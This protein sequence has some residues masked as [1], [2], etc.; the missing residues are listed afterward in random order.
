MVVSSSAH[1]YL[2]TLHISQARLMSAYKAVC[3]QEAGFTAVGINHGQAYC[4]V[5]YIWYTPQVLR[6][7]AACDTTLHVTRSSFGRRGKATDTK[8]YCTVGCV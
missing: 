2:S 3:G 4:T 7:S 5:D 6:L 1:T 8:A